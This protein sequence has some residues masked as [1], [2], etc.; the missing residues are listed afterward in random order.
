MSPPTFTMPMV[1][2]FGVAAAIWL[3]PW[4]VPAPLTFSTLIVAPSSWPTYGANSR[5]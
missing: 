5:A 1:S 4:S 3:L 2:P